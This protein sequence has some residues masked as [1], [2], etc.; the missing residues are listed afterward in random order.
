MSK[1]R[2]EYEADV[3]FEVWRSGGN[4]DAIDEYRVQECYDMGDYPEEA[5]SYCEEQSNEPEEAK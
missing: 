1:S 3:A 5:A 2:R 4:P